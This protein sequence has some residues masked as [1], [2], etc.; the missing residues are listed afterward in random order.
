MYPF[1][2]TMMV[3]AILSL[4]LLGPGSGCRQK[5]S[6]ATPTEG[7][8][9]GRRGEKALSQP[10][11]EKRASKKKIAVGDDL[12]L[13]HVHPVKGGDSLKKPT[14]W[15][16][17]CQFGVP[18]TILIV[19]PFDD[20]ELLAAARRADQYAAQV[21]EK[22]A[23]AV[24]VIPGPPSD[25]CLAAALEWQEKNKLTHSLVTIAHGEGDWRQLG[26]PEKLTI[27]MADEANT[28]TYQQSGFNDANRTD[29]E[30]ALSHTP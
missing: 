22:Q 11:S 16:C 27:L 23:V 13:A 3:F 18:Q 26:A 4:F 15:I 17:T 20:P 1:R 9:P 25:D 6:P 21:G 14:G 29:F 19:S 5:S 8:G 2:T 28:I 12:P 30:A 24:V 10:A 7:T